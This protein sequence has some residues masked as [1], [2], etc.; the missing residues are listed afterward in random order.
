MEDKLIEWR[1]MVRDQGR[2][3]YGIGDFW[4]A[5]D[6]ACDLIEDLE[7]AYAH[8]KALALDTA[9][10]LAD[11]IK[12]VQEL[13]GK[14]ALYRNLA[15]DKIIECSNLHEELNILERELEGREND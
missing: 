2:H 15:Q 9:L 4:N 3:D 13:E 14:A 6:D 11:S 8:Y 7:R 12:Q 5:L 1:L 10:A